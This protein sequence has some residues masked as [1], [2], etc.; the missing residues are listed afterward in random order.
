M[1]AFSKHGDRAGLCEVAV[2]RP[3]ADEALVRVRAAGICNT[4]LEIIRGYM[5]FEGT[6]GHEFV[7]VVEECADASWIGAR[8][9]G[10]INLSCHQ[11]ELCQRGYERHCPTRRVLG[12][13]GKDGAFAEYVTLPIRNLHRVPDNLSDRAACFIEPIAACFEILEQV[14][15]TPHERIAVL[16]D[17]KLGTLAALV[18][19]SHGTPPVLVGKHAAKLAR[20]EQMGIRSALAHD[21]TPKSFDIVVEATGSPSGMELATS[22]VRPR[23]TIVLKSTYH[24]ELKVQAAPWVIDE[25][26]IVGSRC[27]PFPPAL[28]KLGIGQLLPDGL[29]DAVFPLHEAER[30]IEHAAAPGV[31]KVLLQMP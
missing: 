28:A 5:S 21:L 14:I 20:A 22:L 27:G 31:L 9:A 24:G 16:G 2:P 4:D 3:A 17:G 25:L 11:C 18:L 19:S 13:L 10:E 12:I 26:T 15:I 6:L 7:G 1:L 23:G 29:I 30:A 8:V